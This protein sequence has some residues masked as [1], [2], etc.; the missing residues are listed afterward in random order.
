[1]NEAPTNL[2]SLTTRLDNLARQSARPIRRV[3]RTIANTV[4]GQMLPSGVM[5]GGAAMSVRVGEAGSRFTT[6]LDA[7][8]PADMALG[9]YLDEFAR[10]LEAGWGGFTATLEQLPPAEPD[11]IP[12]QYVMQPFKIRLQYLGRHWL[13]VPFELGHDEIDSTKQHELRIARDI[14]SLFEAVGLA[15]PQPIPLLTVEHQ[16]AQKLHAC[17]AIN[18]RTGDNDR[19]HDLVDL[20]ILEHEE[21]IDKPALAKIA[22]RLFKVRDAQPWPPIVVAHPSWPTIYAEAADGLD[23]RVHVDDA[24]VWANDFIASLTTE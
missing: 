12:E 19:A 16:I 21:S 24:V 1:M 11:G 15:E 18:P 13:T 4:V 20:Q 6:D 9:D 3:Q 7:A 8:R 2:R 14:V 23:V 10:R 5:K 22:T 17:T